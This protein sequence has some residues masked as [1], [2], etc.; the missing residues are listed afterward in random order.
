MNHRKLMTTPSW[1]RTIRVVQR[2]DHMPWSVARTCFLLSRIDWRRTFRGRLAQLSR[3]TVKSKDF[4]HSQLHLSNLGNTNEFRHFDISTIRHII[5]SLAI[6]IISLVR[7][8]TYRTWHTYTL[9]I[10]RPLRTTEQLGKY[11]TLLIFACSLQ[12]LFSI[13]S[14]GVVALGS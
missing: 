6:T 5:L 2:H 9:Y 10:L 4:I 7:Q 11:K 12:D 13:S 3:A 1:L 8:D 14:C